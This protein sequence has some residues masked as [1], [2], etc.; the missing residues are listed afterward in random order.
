MSPTKFGKAGLNMAGL[1][2]QI[3]DNSL[4]YYGKPRSLLGSVDDAKMGELHMRLN[5]LI[6]KHKKKKEG[7]VAKDLDAGKYIWTTPAM[8]LLFLQ[9]T[10]EKYTRSPNI[11]E[12]NQSMASDKM[13]DIPEDIKI[14]LPSWLEFK[15]FITEI[16]DH[17]IYHSPEINGTVNTTYLTLEEHLIIFFMQRYRTRQTAEKKLVEFLASLKYYSEIW[18]RAKMYSIL[19]GFYHADSTWLRSSGTSENRNPGRINNGKL[20]ELEVPSMDI[21]AQEFFL[22][23]YSLITKERK[24]FQ[25]S[26][27]GYT[28]MAL[29]SEEKIQHRLMG[30]FMSS[31]KDTNKWSIEIKRIIK[32]I[33][34][35][36][37]DDFDTEYVDID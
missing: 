36:P 4:S 1:K 23:A 8:I 16:Y 10:I 18:Q 9:N 19:V 2:G 5:Q 31:T 24:N 35:H 17:R 12:D 20:D 37:Q 26:K 33:K 14:R 25:E 34:L 15:N 7:R 6:N 28:Y 30:A 3:I 13:S 32:K 29:K 21:Y 11:N 22:H 27:E